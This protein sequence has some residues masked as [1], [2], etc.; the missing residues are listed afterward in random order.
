MKTTMITM[1]DKNGKVAVFSLEGKK[2]HVNNSTQ[3][4]DDGPVFWDGIA[5]AESTG[6]KVER[7]NVEFARFMGFINA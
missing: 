6:V 5:K 4:F 3:Y 2:W 1:T 7:G